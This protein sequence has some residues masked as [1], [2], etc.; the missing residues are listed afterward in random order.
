MQ[1]WSQCSSVPFLRAVV[2]PVVVLVGTA[3]CI[4]VVGSCRINSNSSSSVAVAAFTHF[5][6]LMAVCL[7]EQFILSH[8]QGETDCF[9]L[10]MQLAQPF[11]LQ[12]NSSHD[13]NG[14]ELNSVRNFTPLF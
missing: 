4:G 1:Q 7:R 6:F 3:A 9:Q 13:V 12:P 11:L 8:A 5:E 2:I 14:M 10:L